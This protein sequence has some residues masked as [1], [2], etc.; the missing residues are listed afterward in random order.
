[1]TALS[2]RKNPEKVY[3][4]THSQSKTAS[5]FISK[6]IKWRLRTIKMFPGRYPISTVQAL[7]RIRKKAEVKYSP[8]G[9]ARFIMRNQDDI[10]AIMPGTTATCH[11]KFS[12]LFEE[13]KSWSSMTI[14][15]H[16]Q[17]FGFSSGESWGHGSK[18]EKH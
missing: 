8:I 1:M 10:A 3:I 12:L 7:G 9:W 11:K 18:G 4:F 6:L 15:H 5:D 13:A 16:T 17:L 14:L 2:Y